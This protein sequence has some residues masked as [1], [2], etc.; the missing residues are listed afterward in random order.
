[1]AIIYYFICNGYFLLMDSFVWL[2]SINI[3]LMIQ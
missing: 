3:N 1:M 2:I